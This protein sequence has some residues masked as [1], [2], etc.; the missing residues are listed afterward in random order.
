ML[1]DDDLADLLTCATGKQAM[2]LDGDATQTRG[3]RDDLEGW[4]VKERGESSS[5]VHV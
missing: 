2:G 1:I 4:Y 3:T 5:V